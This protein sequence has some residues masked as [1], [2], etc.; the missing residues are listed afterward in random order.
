MFLLDDKELI[1]KFLQGDDNSFNQLAKRYIDKIYWHSRRILGNHFDA[2]E[3]VQ[4]VLVVMYE[5]LHT[6]N[7]DSSLYTWIYKI[8]YT[9]SLNLL[10]KN[11]IKRFL[12]IDD[13]N[14]NEIP[15]EYSTMEN[16]E[17]KEMLG[18][19][20]KALLKIPPKQRE[21][22]SLRHFEELSYQEISNI[23]GKSIGSIKANYFH[24]FNKLK[25]ILGMDEEEARDGKE[26]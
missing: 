15:S 2:D 23:T 9:R 17:N 24:A 14:G 6:F 5:K 1:K 3:I 13:E 7:S 4:Q 20:D 18:L 21:V 12:G 26:N 22:F 19:I 11:S 16:L 10:K 8:T 25:E